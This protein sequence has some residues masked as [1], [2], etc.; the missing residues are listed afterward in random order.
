MR[1][2]PGFWERWRHDYL[3]ASNYFCKDLDKFVKI[4]KKRPIKCTELQVST[5]GGLVSTFIMYLEKVTRPWHLCAG[6]VSVLCLTAPP[7]ANRLGILL[8][9]D[10]KVSESNDA[11]L[12]SLCD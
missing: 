7:S 3:S 1:S 9:R 6:L 2:L 4:K 10:P 11:F 5:T 12:S 8:C